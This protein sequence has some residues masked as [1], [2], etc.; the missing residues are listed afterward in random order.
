[1]PAKL[2][3]ILNDDAVKVPY[4]ICRHIWKTQ[5]LPQD[6]KKSVSIPAPKKENAKECS[7]YHTILLISY[8]SKAVLKILRVRLHPFVN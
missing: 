2:F 8:I 1:M 7:N 3:K 4:S 5:Q 6:W